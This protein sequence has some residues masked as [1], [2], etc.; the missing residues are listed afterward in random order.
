MSR[1]KRILENLLDTIVPF[2][3]MSLSKILGW[4]VSLESN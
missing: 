4:L 3:T 1:Q 2:M